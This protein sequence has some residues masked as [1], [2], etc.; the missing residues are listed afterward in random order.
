MRSLLVACLE[1]IRVLVIL[2]CAMTGCG[3]GC[4]GVC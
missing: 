1:L 2:K 3:R 4:E